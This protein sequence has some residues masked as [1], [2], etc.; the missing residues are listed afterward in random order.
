MGAAGCYKM[1]APLPIELSF[2]VVNTDQRGL[3]RYCLDA[4]ARERATLDFPTEVLVLDNASRDGSPDV[5]RAHTITDHVIE[6][7]ERADAPAS[8]N[9]LLR[10]AAGRFVLLLNED[11]ELEPGATAALHAAAGADATVGAATPMLVDADGVQLPSAWRFR[12][13]PRAV[14]SRGDAIRTVDWARST[15]L[16]VRREAAERVAG[17][18]ASLDPK[19]ASIGFCRKLRRAGWTTIYVPAARAVHA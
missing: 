8:D 11:T 1:H 7:I 5:A 19:R 12:G 15:A 17:Y 14:Q 3:L 18:D 13:G 9:A 10:R 2:C 4:I 16:L 6:V